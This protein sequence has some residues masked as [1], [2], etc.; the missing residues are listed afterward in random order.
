M[1]IAPAPPTVFGA[2]R[3]GLV[4]AA[5]FAE[6]GHAEL[7]QFGACEASAHDYAYVVADPA[8]MR[9]DLGWRPQVGLRE[10]IRRAVAARRTEGLA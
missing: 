7:M 1:R 5:C 6:L 4:T 2:G 3:V 8:K 10:G 9:R